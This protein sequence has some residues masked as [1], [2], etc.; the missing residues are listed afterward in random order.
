MKDR[1]WFATYAIALG[2][3]LIV[4]WGVLHVFIISVVRDELIR[5]SVNENITSLITLSYLGVAVMISICGILVFYAS[6]AGIKKEEKW[7]KI[8]AFSQACMFGFVTF[9]LIILQPKISVL[10]F[11]ADFVLLLAIATDFFITF[12]ILLGLFLTIKK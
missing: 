1:L 8:I 5:K 9:L 12:F 2:G 6:F 10:G 4:L 7:A 3:I 11:S